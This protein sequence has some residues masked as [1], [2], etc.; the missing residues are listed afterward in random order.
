VCFRERTP[1]ETVASTRVQRTQSRN[2]SS[3]AAAGVK[4]FGEAVKAADGAVRASVRNAR[5]VPT[6]SD[7]ESRGQ[8]EDQLSLRQKTRRMERTQASPVNAWSN[9][10][11][12]ISSNCIWGHGNSIS[13]P[14]RAQTA[15]SARSRRKNC[16]MPQVWR[17]IS[18]SGNIGPHGVW[19]PLLAFGGERFRRILS[20]KRLRRFA[21]ERFRCLSGDERFGFVPGNYGLRQSARA[22]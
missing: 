2:E 16:K 3:S 5:R 10:W 9:F 19:Y 20:H 4:A 8:G 7:Q 12:Q 18:Y 21:N 17:Q 14:E 11:T 6:A 1:M 13:L 22:E 15:L